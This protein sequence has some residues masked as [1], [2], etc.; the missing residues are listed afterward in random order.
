MCPGAAAYVGD[1]ARTGQ[2]GEGL[3]QGTVQRLAVQL[4]TKLV[5]VGAGDRV[6]GRLHSCGRALATRDTVR[7]RHEMTVAAIATQAQPSAAQLFRRAEPTVRHRAE[8]PPRVMPEVRARPIDGT[9][10]S[11]A[12]GHREEIAEYLPLYKGRRAG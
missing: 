7:P 5:M 1:H 4:V 3:K 10:W 12:Y 6:V 11:P 9:T 8:R 2:F